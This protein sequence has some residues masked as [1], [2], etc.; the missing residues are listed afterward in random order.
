[1]AGGRPGG[2]RGAARGWPGDG[3]G[4]AGGRPGDGRAD[5][6][7]VGGWGGVCQNLRQRRLAP[8]GFQSKSSG[9]VY[10][11]SD[12]WKMKLFWSDS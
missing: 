1:M 5:G 7:W 9:F 2:G 10:T 4:A 3:R 12:F 6:G 11:G 8:E